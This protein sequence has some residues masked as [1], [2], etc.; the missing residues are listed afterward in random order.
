MRRK[1]TIS[2]F[3]ALAVLAIGAANAG[4]AIK[5]PPTLV[6]DKAKPAVV[7]LPAEKTAQYD[8]PFKRRFR[9]RR[10]RPPHWRSKPGGYRRPFTAGRMMSMRDA[11]R[12]VRA[13]VPGRIANGA[14]RG[15]FAWFRVISRGRVLNVVVD[16]VTRTLRVRPG[17]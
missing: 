10:F 8:G 9:P 17:F 5:A 6:S 7:T 1:L 11:V 2:L 12:L 4:A 16:R 15:R 3:S 14:L 13:R